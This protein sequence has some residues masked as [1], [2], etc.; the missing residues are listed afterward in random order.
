MSAPRLTLPQP[1]TQVFVA[2]TVNLH[3][4]MEAQRRIRQGHPWLYDNSIRKQNHSGECGDL[5]VIYDN[6]NRFLALGLYDSTSV[7]RVRILQ[8]FKQMHINQ[9]WF[10]E[11]IKKALKLRRELAASTHTTGY[12]VIHGE[13]DALPGIIVDRY[14]DA[15]VVKIYTAAWIPYLRHFLSAL[16]K[17]VPSKW[18][19]L[20]LSRNASKNT[21]LLNGYKNGMFIKGRKVSSPII[22]KENGLS[23]EADI[24][25]GQKTGF[26][27]DQKD[28]RK[29]VEKLSR[30]RT[31]LDLFSYTGGFSVY[32]ARGGA[33]EVISVDMSLPV[34]E[35]AG[36]NMSL[37]RH[38]RW[39]A[40]AKH[41]RIKSDVFKALEMLFKKHKYFDMVI[42]DPP[43]FAQSQSEVSSALAAYARLTKMALRV[44]RSQGIIV[45]ACCSGHIKRDDFMKTIHNGAIVAKRPLKE[46]DRTEQPIDHP[47]KFPEGAYLKCLFAVVP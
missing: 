41:E 19:V 35:A 39:V 37:N 3:V 6:R 29:K 14:A 11:R 5:A 30:N 38:N 40:S 24:L 43:T 13:N 12:R 4:N 15:L 21:R 7:I 36:R 27:L 47:I 23:F 46:I 44:L 28:N 20:R 32:A 18:I 1:E 17:S 2:R 10:E 16:E 25:L 8:R 26:F 9:V 33:K 45:V 22:F 34:L 31:I 42:I